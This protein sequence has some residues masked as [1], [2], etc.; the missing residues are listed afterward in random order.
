VRE[1]E[2]NIETVK[3]MLQVVDRMDQDN[4]LG[5]AIEHQDA[6]AAQAIVQEVMFGGAGR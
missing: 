5:D 1:C 3:R 6:V 2:V 4:R